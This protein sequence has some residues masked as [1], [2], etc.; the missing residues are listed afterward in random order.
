MPIW[1]IQCKCGSDTS[2]RMSFERR[3]KAYGG[4]IPCGECGEVNIP[5]PAIRAVQGVT[6]IEV[7]Q[8]GKTF[9]SSSELDRYCE[10]NDCEAVDPS[11]KRWR[12][13]K[14][15][16]RLGHQ[17]QVQAEG[18]KDI[19]DKRNRWKAEKEDRVRATQQKTID[20]YHDK[21]GS[22]DKQTVEK[23]YGSAE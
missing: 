3:Q 5:H 1:K 14:D 2:Q 9:S 10:A 20:K 22:S 17:E 16:A 12:D 11:S 6:P 8:L 4:N 19:A 21:H 7:K 18:F 15:M 23:A 13:L